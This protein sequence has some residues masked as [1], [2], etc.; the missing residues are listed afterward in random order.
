MVAP[1]LI[2]RSKRSRG[3]EAIA[4]VGD[5]STISA[6]ANEFGVV[7]LVGIGSAVNA[8]TVGADTRS[9]VGRRSLN[10]YSPG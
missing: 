2:T 4:S 1:I 3:W 5:S 8:T 6:A 7:E 10:R 9:K